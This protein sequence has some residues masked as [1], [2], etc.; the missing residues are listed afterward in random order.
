[1]SVR[2]RRRHN[3]AYSPTDTV[4][5]VVVGGGCFMP[6]VLP[7]SP[8]DSAYCVISCLPL[9]LPRISHNTVGGSRQEAVGMSPRWQQ[10]FLGQILRV[11]ISDQTVM[12]LEYGRM[13][14]VRG[15]LFCLF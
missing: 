13:F 7:T 14:V 12:K 4:R 3:F 2:G 5:V 1:M 15:C 8:P 11:S 9:V 6:R 10:E